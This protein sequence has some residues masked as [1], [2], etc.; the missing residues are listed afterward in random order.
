MITAI[1]HLSLSGSD[2]DAS[3]QVDAGYSIPS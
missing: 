1:N 2:L 3:F